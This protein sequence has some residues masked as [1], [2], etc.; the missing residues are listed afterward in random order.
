M[1]RLRNA[2]TRITKKLDELYADPAVRAE[3][4]REAQIQTP[5]Y[6]EEKRR[7]QLEAL[8]TEVKDE[9]AKGSL[10]I[11]QSL[12]Q[13]SRIAREGEFSDAFA[14]KSIHDAG[15]NCINTRYSN[16]TFPS[17]DKIQS[18]AKITADTHKVILGEE[19][20]IEAYLHEIHRDFLDTAA[21]YLELSIQDMDALA[22]DSNTGMFADIQSKARFSEVEQKFRQAELLLARAGLS[23]EDAAKANRNINAL[24]AQNILSY[25]NIPAKYADV[26]E[27][28]S[29]AN[30]FARALDATGA[31]P[32]QR[33][34]VMRDVALKKLDCYHNLFNIFVDLFANGQTPI[35]ALE[36]A[37]TMNN[38]IVED[39][40]SALEQCAVDEGKYGSTEQTKIEGLRV[41]YTQHIKPNSY[42]IEIRRL[43]GGL[44][45]QN[46]GHPKATKKKIVNTIRKVTELMPKAGLDE[47][48]FYEL[49]GMIKVIKSDAG[50][51]SKPKP[52]QSWRKNGRDKYQNNGQ[53]LDRRMRNFTKKHR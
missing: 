49:R 2:W 28:E 21:H 8:I 44:N 33:A 11:E 34:V 15:K 7:S 38:Q 41:Q 42:R 29:R 23:E 50:Y 22:N 25:L 27:F 36:N 14:R 18:I 3:Q 16:T 26:S 52:E 13:V 17:M 30:S 45:T 20:D 53:Y 43:L 6:Q 48:Q 5:E 19:L 47:D 37:V 10:S 35:S 39:V 46:N 12:Q 40:A 4:T 31:Q 32:A 1:G 24:F 51:W 9:A